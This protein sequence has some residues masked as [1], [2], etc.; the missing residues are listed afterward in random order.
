M[1]LKPERRGLVP[2][3]PVVNFNKSK[4][5]F[6]DNSNDYKTNMFARCSRIRKMSCGTNPEPELTE[7]SVGRFR[8]RIDFMK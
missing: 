5:K 3:R 8:S 6:K 1:A 7:S 4:L 2:I